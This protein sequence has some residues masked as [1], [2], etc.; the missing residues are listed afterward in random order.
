MGIK[1]ARTYDKEFKNNAVSLYKEGNRTY[2]D[3]ATNL[4]IPYA[5]LVGW[6][7]AKDKSDESAFPGKGYLPP[8]EERFKALER[9]NEQ[10]KRERDILKKALAIFSSQ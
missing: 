1:N 3:V 7:R 6:V 4:G 8:A 5:T 10:L 2:Q 9:E